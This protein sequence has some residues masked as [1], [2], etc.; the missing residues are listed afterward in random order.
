MNKGG[1]KQ[2]IELSPQELE[3]AINLALKR[4]MTVHDI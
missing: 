2:D 3:E 1:F 4:Y